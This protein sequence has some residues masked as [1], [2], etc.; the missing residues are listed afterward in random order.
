MSSRGWHPCH[1][2]VLAVVP[3]RVVMPMVVLAR[4]L[5]LAVFRQQLLW[6]LRL[7]LV[8]RLRLVLVL[9]PV[10][11]RARIQAHLQIA[12]LYW[13]TAPTSVGTRRASLAVS[14]C[15]KGAVA[16]A[17]IVSALRVVVVILSAF[18]SASASVVVAVAVAVA[19]VVASL[20]G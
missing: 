3:V 18:A 5:L 4:V 2:F 14:G 1:L 7:V 10:A 11:A 8:L 12:R 16:A 13:G 15:R 6:L 9:W 20:W 17:A 19:V